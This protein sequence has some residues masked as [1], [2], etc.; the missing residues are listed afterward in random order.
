MVSTKEK[1]IFLMP[2]KTA[3]NSL[4]ECLLDSSLTIEPFNLPYRIPTIHLYLSELVGYYKIEDIENYKVIQ[5]VRDPITRFVSSYF[6]QLRITNNNDS[7]K[8]NDMN[9]SEFTNHLYTCLTKEGSFLKNFFGDIQFIKKSIMSGKSFGGSRT[10][11]NQHQWNDLGV[12]MT[13]V[14]LEDITNDISLLS[15]EV[16]VYLSDLEKKNENKTIVDYDT[17]ITDDIRKTLKEIYRKD[18]KILGY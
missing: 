16:G 5:V 9:L 3:S 8:I 13:Y 14:K 2:P 7:V 15:K 4:K 6:H 17:L 18:F 12:D 1:L 11:L 10:Y